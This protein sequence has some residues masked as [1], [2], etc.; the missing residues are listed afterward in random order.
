MYKCFSFVTFGEQRF[1]STGF[2]DRFGCIIFELVHEVREFNFIV[3]RRLSRNPSQ[4]ELSAFD[5]QMPVHRGRLPPLE[6]T[7]IPHA[8]KPKF[9]Y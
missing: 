9:H 2:A 8:A 7:R 5:D 3:E 4:V 1:S 6:T